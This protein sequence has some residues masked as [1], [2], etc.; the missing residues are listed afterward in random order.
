MIDTNE[1]NIQGEVSARGTFYTLQKKP[2]DKGVVVCVHG[3]GS[4]SAQ[5]SGLA[6]ALVNEGYTVLT[7]DLIGRGASAYPKDNI[8]DGAAHVSQ[9]R[10][11]ILDLKLHKCARYH[12]VAH[13]MGGAI[14]ALYASEHLDEVDSLVLLSPAGLMDLGPLRLVRGCCACFQ[15]IVKRVVHSGQER[16]WR[17]DFASHKGKSLDIENNFVD[18]LAA[19][20]AEN[21]QMY[22]AFWQ[23]V[24]QFPLSGIDAAVERVASSDHVSVLL[25]WGQ[26]DKAVPYTPNYSRWRGYLEAE[27]LEPCPSEQQ[28]R[29][30][31][32]F[33][34]YADMGHGFLLEHAG[35]V[36]QDLITFFQAV[37][38]VK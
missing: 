32:Q 28:G 21:P 8:F 18:Q 9:L 35:A 1:A 29:R 3:I 25:A 38:Q 13:S 19:V 36:H 34:V 6:S 23:S 37:E 30:V 20:N 14:A 24:L 15:G 22:E 4:F 31:R 12:I 17:D 10:N 5:F 7:Y 33:E 16:A 11:L 26:L 27:A 2:G